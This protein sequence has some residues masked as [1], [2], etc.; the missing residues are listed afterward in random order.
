MDALYKANP[1]GRFWLKLDGTDV[2]PCLMH[3]MKGVWNGDVDLGDGKLKELRA[4][5]ETR[6]TTF[7]GSSQARTRAELEGKLRERLD[8]LKA[9][10]DFLR[11]GLNEAVDNY[12]KKYNNNNTSEEALKSANWDVV[13]FQTLLQQAQSMASVMETILSTLNP[14]TCTNRIVQRAKASIKDIQVDQYL[15][16]IFKKKRSVAS[17]VLV[18]MLSDEKRSRKP[19]ALPV[20]FI[21]YRT[22]KDQYIRD[23]SK[24]IKLKMKERGLKLV[25]KISVSCACNNVNVFYLMLKINA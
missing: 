2:K 8:E 22:L 13:E 16:N 5:Y 6:L 18:F 20:R 4:E 7:K 21:P 25:G 9:D 15:R 23:L 19:Y 1:S 17:H 11:E 10:S 24:D 3:S 12:R 14:A